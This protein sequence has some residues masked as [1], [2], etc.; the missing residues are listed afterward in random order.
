MGCITCIDL[1]NSVVLRNPLNVTLHLHWYMH[2]LNSVALLK[3]QVETE[4]MFVLH[5]DLLLFFANI[6]L[7]LRS[8]L[9]A[10]RGRRHDEDE[11]KALTEYSSITT[12][13]TYNYMGTSPQFQI[14][15]IKLLAFLN[16]INSYAY[17]VVY[18]PR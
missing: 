1:L 5:I 4:M 16:I 9:V 17:A 14:V 12:R 11:R 8:S 6:N 13:T 2:L 15:A 10:T 3:C 18:A 7:P